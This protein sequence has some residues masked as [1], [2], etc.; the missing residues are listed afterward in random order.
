MNIYI[1]PTSEQGM[2]DK[3][4]DQPLSNTG[5]VTNLPLLD[6]LRAAV[7]PF[8]YTV[9][10]SDF[11][12]KEK[13][14][15]D[16]ILVVQNHP[17]ETLL[18]RALYYLKRLKTRGGFVL[19]RR[20]FLYDN[21][22]S[23]KRRV[24]IQAE[25]PMVMPYVYRNLR[26]VE[27]S[28][29]YQKIFIAAR[30]YSDK[31]EYFH[32]YSYRDHDIVSPHFANPK[33]K[34]LILLNANARPH[35]LKHELYSERLKAIRYFSD[36]PGF[37]LYGRGWDKAPR[38]PFYFHYKKF[39]ARAWRGAVEDKFK[40]MSQY[41]FTICYENAT[42]GGYVSEKIFDCLATGTIPIYLG[43]PDITTLVPPD[44]F[45]D[46]R[47]FRGYPELHRHLASLSEADCVRYRENILR[48]LHDRSTM[49]GA[50]TLI[51]EIV[52]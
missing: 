23:F 48:F 28:G 49:R 5:G 25:S 40:V 36:I 22:R 50:K 14:Q 35:S 17:G 1:L 15:P 20:R 51:N 13:A 27:Q 29:L 47:K 21:Y 33:D 10:T 19:A 3:L 7:K 18:W 24:L 34:F 37:D 43:A 46:F 26:A 45:I 30:G 32:R 11:W 44:C 2:N 31:A 52:G 8:G 42:Y 16:D 41:R 12:S 9:H 38:H 4:F 6:G 39:V